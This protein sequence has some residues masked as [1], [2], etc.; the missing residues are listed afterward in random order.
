MLAGPV[1]HIPI[2]R[3]PAD[4]RLSVYA[5]V[6][7][8]HGSYDLEFQLRGADGAVVWRWRPA[9]PLDHPNPLV[10]HQL[11]FHELLLTVPA[12]GRYDLALHAGGDEIGH[13]PL[14]IGPAEVF[15]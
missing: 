1:S 10:L 8:G 4:V 11:A 15:A 5:H 2:P 12:A 14:L 9:Q 7:G 3:F 13:Q 6:T